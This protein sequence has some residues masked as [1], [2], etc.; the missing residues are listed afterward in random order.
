MLKPQ[1]QDTLT[2]HDSRSILSMNN[3]LFQPLTAT[4]RRVALCILRP[5]VIGPLGA[6]TN[7]GEVM[8]R[9]DRH[10]YQ[11]TTYRIQR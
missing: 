8:G 11:N 1:R 10:C 4:R 2:Y 9:M 7:W 3:G 5:R 6:L